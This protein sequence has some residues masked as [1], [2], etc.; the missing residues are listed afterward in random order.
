MTPELSWLIEQARSDY[1]TPR[2]RG[3]LFYFKQFEAVI[4]LSGAE[5]A[6]LRELARDSALRNHGLWWDHAEVRFALERDG[7]GPH[8]L[9]FEN[10]PHPDCA[11]VRVASI[12]PHAERTASELAEAL[13][14]FWNRLPEEHRHLSML[15]V[16]DELSRYDGVSAAPALQTPR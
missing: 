7:G 11:L 10:C 8:T 3:A 2:W 15:G 13:K 5:P 4:A 14:R 16:I 6:R 12:V 9:L 1:A